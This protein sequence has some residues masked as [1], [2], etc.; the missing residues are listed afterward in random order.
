[1]TYIPPD[2][3]TGA[4]MRL[5]DGKHNSEYSPTWFP[6]YIDNPNYPF[7]ACLDATNKKWNGTDSEEMFLKSLKDMPSDW[8][9]RT[10]EI[11]YNTNSNGYRAP[12]WDQINWKESI[13]LFGCSCTYGVGLAEDE[14]ISYYLQ[15]LTGRQVVNLGVPGGSNDLMLQ[16]SISLLERYDTPYSVVMNWTCTD[17]FRYFSEDRYYDAGSWLANHK[18]P[19][20]IYD[21]NVSNLWKHLYRDRTNELVIAYNIG[22]SAK[23]IWQNRTHYRTVS[24]FDLSAH[25]LRADKFFEIDNK[26]RDRLHPGHE[27]AKAVATYIASTYIKE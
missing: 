14:T 26:A 20:S 8:R 17:R 23:W 24:Y 9:Y 2:W 4:R 7:T 21:M 27:N 6:S 18:G 5:D 22:R 3:T 12:E 16:N 13:V 19:S 25:Y 11:V 1:M 10:K 15:E